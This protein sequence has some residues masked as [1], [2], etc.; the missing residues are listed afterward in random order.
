MNVGQN[1]T[2]LLPDGVQVTAEIRAITKSVPALSPKA[3]P[4]VG[5]ATLGEKVKEARKKADLTQKELAAELKMSVLTI[6]NIE[7]D[8]ILK[9][10]PNPASILAIKQRFG[11]P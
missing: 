8:K 2:I 10:G 4:H 1:I 6:N 5:G 3:A 9:R 7:K 11:I